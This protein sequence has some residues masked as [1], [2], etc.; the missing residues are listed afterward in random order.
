MFDSRP[1]RRLEGCHNRRR[2]RRQKRFMRQIDGPICRIRTWPPT[3]GGA[4]V[5][6]T[7][8]LPAGVHRTEQRRC[9]PSEGK[10][11]SLQGIQPLE[12][13]FAPANLQCEPQ[14]RAVPPSI[15]PLECA[16]RVEA[17]I[18]SVEG[19]DYEPPRRQHRPLPPAARR[20]PSVA[21]RLA[22]TDFED[23][24]TTYSSYLTLRYTSFASE[25]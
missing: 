23:T 7:S 13:S 5:H 22:L 1:T 17:R 24:D 10:M 9:A 6:G 2:L 12:R 19:R 3:V 4:D 14:V 15:G 8:V 25:R 21:A 16:L 11:P 20:I 18:S